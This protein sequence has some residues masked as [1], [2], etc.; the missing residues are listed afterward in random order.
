MC[1]VSTC[2]CDDGVTGVCLQGGELQCAVVEGLSKLML[3]RRLSSA[4]LLSRLLLLW[5]NPLEE[6][7]LLLR[8]ILATF[9]SVFAFTDMCVL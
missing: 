5:F 9:F 6:E 2:Y 4:S 8:H 3:S 7:N 1:S